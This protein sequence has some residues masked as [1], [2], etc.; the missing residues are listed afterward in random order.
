MMISTYFILV[1]IASL[2]QMARTLP[3]PSDETTGSLLKRYKVIFQDCGKNEEIKARSAWK[4]AVELAEYTS[5]KTADD[6]TSFQG[7][8]T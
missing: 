8:N 2:L 5:E 1:A 3:S 4:D 7:T 6:K